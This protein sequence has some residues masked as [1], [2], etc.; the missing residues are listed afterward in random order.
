MKWVNDVALGIVIG[1][2]IVVVVAWQDVVES[3]SRLFAFAADENTAYSNEAKLLASLEE[4][5]S[6]PSIR[7]IAHFERTLSGLKQM[8]PRET[9]EHI[10]RALID[11]RRTAAIRNHNSSIENIA[12]IAKGQIEKRGVQPAGISCVEIIESIKE[13]STF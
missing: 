7:N 10:A 1:L 2:A 11:A 4:G 8:C 12:M 5:K 9:S 6:V 13:Y 3:T